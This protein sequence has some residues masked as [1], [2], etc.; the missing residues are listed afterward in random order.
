MDNWLLFTLL[1]SG[2]DRVSSHVPRQYHFV[3]QNVTWG[4]AQ[5]YCRDNFT[6]LATVENMA[7]MQIMMRAVKDGY[8]QM[9]WIG[10]NKTGSGIWRWSLQDGKGQS[11]DETNFTAWGGGEPNE[12]GRKEDCAVTGGGKWKDVTCD[13]EYHF[14]CYNETN[15]EYTPIAESKNWTYAQKYCRENYTDL[16]SVRDQSENESI[17]NAEKRLLEMT[18]VNEGVWIGLFKDYW[19]WSDQTTSLFRFWRPGIPDNSAGNEDCAVTLLNEEGKWGD[20]KCDEKHPFFCQDNKRVLVRENKTWLEA[21]EYCEGHGM[22]LVSVSSEK[23]FGWVRK[24][25]KGASGTTHVWLG[26]YYICPLDLWLWIS[27]V[28]VCCDNWAPGNGTGTHGCGMAG[29]LQAEDGKW[30]SR[31][32]NVRLNFIC[33][34]EGV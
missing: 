9:A 12:E 2:L 7:D 33:T 24:L 3:N 16:A 32:L 14:M 27:G 17:T 26:L 5:A 21:F 28:T 6:D 8:N 29:A 20:S 15:K 34:S 13:T 1:L 22:S 31:P 18:A 11:L 25:A 19:K 4:E 10:L 23:V 30:V